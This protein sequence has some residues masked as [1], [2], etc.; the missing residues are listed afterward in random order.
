MSIRGKIFCT[1]S[2]C[3]RLKTNSYTVEM[4]NHSF[5]EIV[6]FVLLQAMHVVKRT[7]TLTAVKCSCILQ[8]CVFW[9]KVGR[10][11]QCLVAS[12]PNVYEEH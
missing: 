7:E 4:D 3:A 8:K 6:N 11:Q 1:E 9:G 2:Y 5:G 10:G 12:Q